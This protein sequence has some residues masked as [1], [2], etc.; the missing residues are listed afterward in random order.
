MMSKKDELNIDCSYRIPDTIITR[1]DS[2]EAVTIMNLDDYG[3][4]Y[5]IKGPAALAWTQLTN[6]K[7][8]AAIVTLLEKEYSKPKE[9]VE[10]K[11]LDL[12]E[13]LHSHGLIDI[14]FE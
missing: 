12:L 11:L 1:T 8:L 13:D 4:F 2:S 3:D 6:K 9:D 7:S 10:E 14:D 5:E